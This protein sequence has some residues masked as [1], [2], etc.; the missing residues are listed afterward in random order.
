MPVRVNYRCVLHYTLEVETEDPAV[1]E[2]VTTDM[3]MNDV[4]VALT[5]FPDAYNFD[6]ECIGVDDP[7][8]AVEGV[9]S[10]P[11]KPQ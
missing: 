9:P 4:L 8:E 10:F 5:K 3:P 11:S 6:S 7:G 2:Q 1:A